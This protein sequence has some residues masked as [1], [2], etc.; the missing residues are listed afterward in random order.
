METV[1]KWDL[2]AYLVSKNLINKHQHG[3]IAK[4]STSTQ[5]LKCLNFW[6]A[7][8][9]KKIHVDECYIDFKSAF[10]SV[11]H[12]TLLHKLSGYRVLGK[13]LSWFTAFSL[14]RE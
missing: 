7:L 13:L 5:L 1:I 2:I 10:G 6:S 3:F 4:H 9:D 14:N 11:S 12:E 8:I